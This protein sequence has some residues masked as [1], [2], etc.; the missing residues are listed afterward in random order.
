MNTINPIIVSW[1]TKLIPE[2]PGTVAG[3]LNGCAWCL[4]NLGATWAG[5]LA[6]TVS[7]NPIVT[8]LSLLGLLLVLGFFII[9]FVPQFKPALGTTE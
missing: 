1:G 8:S 2:S 4:A 9:L 6:K 7:V 5:L 3:L